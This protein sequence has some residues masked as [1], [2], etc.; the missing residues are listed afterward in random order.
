[1]ENKDRIIGIS[2]VI[3][4]HS[5]IRWILEIVQLVGSSVTALRKTIKD[6]YY[7]HCIV[8]IHYFK[9]WMNWIELPL[10]TLTLVFIISLLTQK[11]YC[12]L[13]WQWQIG[14]FVMLFTWFELIV[15][16]SQFQI[17]GVYALMFVR[18][19]RTFVKVMILAFLLIIAFTLTFYMLLSH[20][21]YK[22]SSNYALVSSNDSPPESLSIQDSP[23]KY[24]GRSILKITAMSTGELNSDSFFR[25]RDSS[26]IDLPFPGA[27][28]LLWIIFLIFMTILLTNMLVCP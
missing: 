7:Q 23:F 27:T 5:F 21:G 28:V 19:L 20:P 25:Y 11:G 22:V 26:D 12:L 4:G 1:M 3:L 10:Y 24:A 15:F 14:A 13:E 16:F 8:R 2:V 18:V 9:S 17:V 6:K